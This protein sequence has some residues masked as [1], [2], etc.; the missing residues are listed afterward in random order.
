MS[1]VILKNIF[2]CKISAVATLGNCLARSATSGI[3]LCVVHEYVCIHEGSGPLVYM[4]AVALL[5]S[6]QKKWRRTVASR[7]D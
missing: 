1:D 5:D 6:C 7:F 3:F 2:F 4:E